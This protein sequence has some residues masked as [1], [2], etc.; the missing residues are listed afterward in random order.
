WAGKNSG[1]ARE[2]LLSVDETFASEVAD[3]GLVVFQRY[4]AEDAVE[5]PAFQ[6]LIEGKT[7]ILDFYKPYGNNPNFKLT[8]KPA[9]AEVSKDG[10]LG[11]TYG[12]YQATTADENGV[13]VTRVGKY[14]TVWRRE[15]DGTCK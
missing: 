2:E 3:K 13:P 4:Y 12:H 15:Y 7:A 5:M 6:P 9:R 8:W 10:D 14:V 1:A 11:F